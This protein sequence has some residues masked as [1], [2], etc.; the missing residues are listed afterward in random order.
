M[1]LGSLVTYFQLHTSLLLLNTNIRLGCIYDGIKHSSL[2]IKSVIHYKQILKVRLPKSQLYTCVLLLI[3]NIRL[4]CK[5]MIVS[6]AL[7]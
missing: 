6:Y 2:T 3:T 5:Y 4:G 7:A 1:R